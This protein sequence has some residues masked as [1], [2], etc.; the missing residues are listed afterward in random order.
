MYQKSKNDIEYLNKLQK[1]R[2][3]FI[4]NVSHE[5]R[6]PIFTIHGYIETLLEGAIDDPNVNKQFLQKTMSLKKK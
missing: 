4:A 1:M 6:T 3:Q 2:S 5:L